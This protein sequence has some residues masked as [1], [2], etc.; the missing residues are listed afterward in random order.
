MLG[1]FDKQRVVAR[2]EI[3]L[4]S[5]RRVRQVIKAIAGNPFE[6]FKETVKTSPARCRLG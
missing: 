1:H 2:R 3:A 4:A 5:N 6:T